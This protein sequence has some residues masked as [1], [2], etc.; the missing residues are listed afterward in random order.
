MTQSSWRGCARKCPITIVKGD[1]SNLCL[2]QNGWYQQRVP[3]LKS[4][5]AMCGGRAS[6][7][8]VDRKRQGCKKGL[9]HFCEPVA[10]VV[11]SRNPAALRKRWDSLTPSTLERKHTILSLNF[12]LPQKYE[13][14]YKVDMLDQTVPDYN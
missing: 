2:A 3:G 8:S 11:Q 13:E 10:A 9:K 6:L 7:F 14:R 1:T 5:P 12:H 4:S